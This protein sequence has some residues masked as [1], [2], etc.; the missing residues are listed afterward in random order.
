MQRRDV[1]VVGAG[2]MGAAT[3]WQLARRGYS[4]T[5]LEQF[6]PGHTRGSSHGASRIF[7]LGYPDPFYVALAREALACWQELEMESD[8]PLLVPTGIVDFGDSDRM[9]GVIDALDAEGVPLELLPPDVARERWPGIR[10]DGPACFQ[11]GGGRLAA[12]AAI[13]AMLGQALLRG[14]QIRWEAPVRAI[15]PSDDGVRVVTADH[16]YDAGVVVVA[17]GAWV[18]SLL[19]GLVVLPQLRVT[20]ESVFHFAPREQSSYWPSFIHH[21]ET[22]YY[23]LETPGEGVKVAEHHTG[24]EVGPDTRDFVPDPGS[25]ER[26]TRFVDATLPGLVPVPGGGTT[27]LYTSTE[28]E[29][30]VIDRRGGIVVVSACSGHGFKFAPLVGRMAADLVD[31]AAPVDRFA[32]PNR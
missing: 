2:V 17:A 26:V 12:G 3:A 29:D 21:D 5:V 32:L 11:P 24:L 25:R 28:T 31:G 16:V 10:F 8:V 13:L 20:Q 19:E 7:R 1:I 27:C 18:V 9:A 22:T 15:E 30:F 6:E 4:V 14:A 23:G